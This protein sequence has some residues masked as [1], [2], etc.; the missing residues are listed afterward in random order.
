MDKIREN[1]PDKVKIV[2]RDF[3]LGFH[4]DAVPA[5]VAANCAGE[6]DKYWEMHD[7]LM[8]NQRALDEATLVSHANSL[9]LDMDKWATCR[10]DPAQTAEVQK[11]QEDGAKVGVTG[12]PAFFVNGIMLSGALPYEQ[13][14]TIIERELAAK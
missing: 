4:S 6:Q 14:E 11:D 1:Y 13:F 7:L 12:T 9:S 10:K 2:F 8:S 5:A 3:P